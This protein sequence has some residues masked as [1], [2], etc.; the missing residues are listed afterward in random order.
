MLLGLLAAAIPPIIH[1][2]H[3]RKAQV[4]RFPALEFIR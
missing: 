3:R 2:I 1:L 4:V